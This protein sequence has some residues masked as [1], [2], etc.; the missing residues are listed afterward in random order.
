MKVPS[1]RIRL[2][3][4]AA[5][6]AGVLFLTAGA[7]GNLAAQASKT[8]AGE[9]S[10]FDGKS[11]AGWRGYKKTDAAGGRWTIQDGTLTLPPKDGRDTRGA[12]DI[13]SAETFDLFELTWEWKVAQGA[14]SGLK[15]FVLEDRD[16][17]IG[18]E[19]QLIDDER[20]PDAKIGPHRQTA[21]FYDVLAAKIPP[22]PGLKKP[23]GEWN[24]SQIRVAPSRVVKGGTRVYH[25]LNGVRV[26]EYELDSPELDAAIEKSKFKGIERFGKLQKGHILLQDHGDQ[27]WF[28]NIKVQRL[29]SS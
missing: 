17:A 24:S 28:R 13:I 23:A 10:L 14:N 12:R 16:S 26:L 29:G 6:V 8:G 27:V 11:L 21:A 5:C 9:S 15:Y 19:Y 22:A 25:Y 4:P 1:M 7:P 18:H 3:F 2:V 20:H